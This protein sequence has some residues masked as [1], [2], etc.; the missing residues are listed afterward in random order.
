[1]K[2]KTIYKRKELKER[3]KTFLIYL[4]EIDIDK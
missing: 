1:M 2:K 4:K 3:E